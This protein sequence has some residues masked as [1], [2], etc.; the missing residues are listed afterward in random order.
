MNSVRTKKRGIAVWVVLALVAVSAIAFTSG[1]YLGEINAEQSVGV[2][3]IDDYGRTI[4]LKGTP[5][6]IV[7]TAPT[8]TEIL[9][10]VGAGDNVVGVDDYSD[11]PAEVANLTKVGTVELNVE[12]ILSLDPDLIVSSDLVPLAQL[13]QLEQQGIPYVILAARTIDDVFRDIKMVG[14]ITG[15]IQEAHDLVV[16]L[17]SRVHAVENKTLADSVSK[18]KV[19]LEFYPMWTYG[20]GSFGNDLI[21]LAG[22][23]NIAGNTNDE[24]VPVTDEFVIAQNPDMII[25]TVG[26]NYDG[27]TPDTIAARPGWSG[28]SA[29][30]GSKMYP[31]DDNLVSRYGPRIVDALEQLAEII[32]PELF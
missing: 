31:I 9:F 15:H 19:Y 14:F 18:P 17:Q 7:S 26:Q 30:A 23:T 3:V 22:G 20:S 21:Q 12:V 27:T 8:P 16:Q 4:E 32:H 29:V 25:Y 5:A 13:D 24:Y 10:A 28:I 11:Y 1:Y 2:T 6:R